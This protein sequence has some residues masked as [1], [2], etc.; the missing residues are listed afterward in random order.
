MQNLVVLG[1]TGTIGRNT[2][3]VAARHAD[4]LQVLGL[5]AQ[6]DAEGLF[7]LCRQHRP[8]FAVLQDP[9]AAER[10]RGLCREAGLACEVGSGAEAICA[11]AAHAEAGQVMS[12]IVGAAGLLPTLAA[13]RAGK[14][15]LIANKEP[16]VMAGA[17]LM[18]EA[19]RFGA[20]LI[21]I[22]SEHNAIFQCLPAPARCGEV[23]RGVRRL[24]L[25]AS[26]G[27]FRET[28]LAQLETVTPQQ[29]VRHPNWV[30]GQKI[31]VDSA[32]MMNKGLELI[33]A[34][35]LYRLPAGQLD[36]VIHPESAIH[37]IVEY[38]DGS[39]LAQ[40]GQ[41]D[42]RVPIAH[43]LAWPERWE[44]G[45]GG[46]DLAALGR[47]R[48]EAPDERRFPCLR[49]ARRA[50]REGGVLPN[51]LNAANEIAVE[52]FLQ[53]RLDYPGI[54]AVIEEV[55]DAAG[56]REAGADLDSIL[57]L[58]AWARGVATLAVG[59]RGRSRLHA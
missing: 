26:G 59:E 22:D 46:L 33:E 18:A 2:L 48:F 50:L 19:E 32:T 5:S 3:D 37:S 57:A 38:V 27:P 8:R 36:V 1:A 52:A 12:A 31:S 15:V 9:A 28:P 7:E 51:V 4:K 49:L 10:L 54:P 53:H 25:T 11:L 42:M 17:L 39:M 40:L 43:A 29:A 30:M 16:L 24:V 47:F 45:V 34:A 41:P 56:G 6:R 13:V 21:P 55:M 20:T 44:S 23:P 14:R 35:V 58:D